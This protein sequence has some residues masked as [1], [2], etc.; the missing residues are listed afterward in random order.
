V[1]ARP[2]STVDASASSTAAAEAQARAAATLFF[3]TL[4]AKHYEQACNMMS[5]RFYRVNKVP[6]KA[7]C[8]LGLR[9][10]F[11]GVDAVRFKI[12]GVHL[13][14]DRAVIQALADRAPGK[15]VLIQERGVFK[16]LSLRGD[17]DS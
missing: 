9:V 1:F 16:V 14:D 13:K 10:G 8:V 7:R 4:N 15:I 2:A 11:M 5:A 12:I 6:D 17:D 3:R